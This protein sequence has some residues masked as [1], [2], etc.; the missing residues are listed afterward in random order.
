VPTFK[1]TANVGRTEAIT[2]NIA[3]EEQ[4]AQII[5]AN[6]KIFFPSPKPPISAGVHPL[7]K[8]LEREAAPFMAPNR[9][10]IDPELRNFGH[11]AHLQEI[12]KSIRIDRLF[13]RI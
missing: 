4:K 12:F 11:K 1:K 3:V 6:R 2:A 5:A 10:W 13:G 8:F 9:N 7:R